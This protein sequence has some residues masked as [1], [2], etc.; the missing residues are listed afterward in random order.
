[1]MIVTANYDGAEGR[2]VHLRGQPLF[3]DH[4][5]YLVVIRND[6][7]Q[8]TALAFVANKTLERIEDVFEAIIEIED[9]KLR[10]LEVK[11]NLDFKFVLSRILDFA[12]V[13]YLDDCCV[14]RSRDC[15]SP[16][17]ITT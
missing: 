14:Q 4:S 15:R 7:S 8:F 9:R 2:S 13:L 3:C 12:A 10:I 6:R 5:V 1:M 17:F 16:S 11:T